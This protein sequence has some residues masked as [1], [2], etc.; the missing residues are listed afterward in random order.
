MLARQFVSYPVPVSHCPVCGY[1]MDEAS[2]VAG[3]N[4]E[5]AEK[6]PSPGAFTMCLNCG[7]ALVFDSNLYLR[8]LTA[9]EN[10]FVNNTKELKALFD[11]V[12]SIIVEMR[13]ES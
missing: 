7:E 2:S 12:R 10:Q 11:H 1:K 5:E 8:K 13:T 9:N 3:S 4:R 6:A